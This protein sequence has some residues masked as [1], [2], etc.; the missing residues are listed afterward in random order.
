MGR[1]LEESLVSF[2]AALTQRGITPEIALPEQP[3]VRQLDRAALKRV[4]QNLL[5]NALKYSGGDL[6]V[7][8]NEAGEIWFSNR[9][10]GLDAVTADKLFDR[11]YTVESARR[12]T[13]LGLSIA[14]HLTQK[15]GGT[16][17]AAYSDGELT[18]HL[19][20]PE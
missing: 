1:V 13:G 7:H 14:K 8:M 20:F 2:Y 5:S 18:I 4:F 16:I 19:H 17:G 6:A 12:S 9:A 10:E 15:M 11:F 3:V